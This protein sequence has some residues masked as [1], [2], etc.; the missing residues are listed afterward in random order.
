MG[1]GISV[2]K[3]LYGLLLSRHQGEIVVRIIDGKY[4]LAAA[5]FKDKT[6]KQRGNVVI[7]ADGAGNTV[8]S[9]KWSSVTCD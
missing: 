4:F 9:N 2:P 1:G 6:D 3:D 5:V 7:V 8:Y